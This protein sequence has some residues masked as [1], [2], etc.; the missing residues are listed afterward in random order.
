MLH[1]SENRLFT[2]LK[3]KHLIWYPA[4][5][6]MNGETMMMMHKCI[7]IIQCIAYTRNTLLDC[8]ISTHV[9]LYVRVTMHSTLLKR[10]CDA[11]THTQLRVL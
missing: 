6:I 5:K 7:H 3:H 4:A 2:D 9:R 1:S 11:H 10:D 8:G